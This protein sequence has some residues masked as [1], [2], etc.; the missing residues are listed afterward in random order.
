MFLR[1]G[2]L[3]IYSKFVREHPCRSAIS[4]KLQSNFIEITLRHGCPPVNLLHIF[5]EHL[6]PGPPL[7]GCF[8]T[9]KNLYISIAKTRSS[10][11]RCSLKKMFQ[12]FRK[13]HRKTPVL[14]SLFNKVAGLKTCNLIK[15]RF[16][17][18]CFLLKF[19][20]FFRTP[21]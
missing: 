17:R 16:Q 1:K 9:F 4:K 13:L 14:E 18:R 12:K 20:K 6:F 2:V 21:L 15:K 7:G 19:L 8:C 3:K 10:H 5:L 11:R